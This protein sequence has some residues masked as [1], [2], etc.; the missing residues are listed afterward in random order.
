M[1]GPQRGFA[2][3][4][5]VVGLLLS[6]GLAVLA[7]DKDNVRLEVSVTSEKT[8][9]PIDSASVYIKFKKKHLLW[10]DARREWTV[11]TNREGRALLPALPPGEVLVQVVAR[12]WRTYGRFHTLTG[13]KHRLEIKLKKPRKWY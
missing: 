8:G 4:S 2:I 13:P 9:Q 11:K 3:A 1:I 7:G 6:A 5:I 10:K 12:G